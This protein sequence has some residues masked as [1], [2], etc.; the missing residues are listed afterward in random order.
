MK[1][2]KKGFTLIE[3]LIVIAIIGILAGVI[4]VSTSSARSKAQRANALQSVKSVMPYL[5]ELSASGTTIITG[6]NGAAIST[7]NITAWP[8]ISSTSCTYGTY[9]SNVS[10]QIV[11]TAGNF[12]CTFATGSCL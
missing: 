4:L 11:C 6:S 1:N 9:T 12:V 7:G 5:A 3:L 10:Q 8:D 2:M